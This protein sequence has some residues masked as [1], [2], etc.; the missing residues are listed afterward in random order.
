MTTK[1]TVRGILRRG[2]ELLCGLLAFALFMWLPK[3]GKEL[4]VYGILLAVV[5]IV[6]I[7]LFRGEHQ[8]YWPRKPEE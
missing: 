1:T 5:I 7:I 6:I 8:G 4:L 2:C 3:T